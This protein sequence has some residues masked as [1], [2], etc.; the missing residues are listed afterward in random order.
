MISPPHKGFAGDTDFNP[1]TFGESKD[2]ITLDGPNKTRYT[3]INQYRCNTLVKQYR[4]ATITGEDG[5][6]GGLVT[7]LCWRGKKGG[8]EGMRKKGREGR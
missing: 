1:Q 6:K 3:L 2:A 5:R 8:R 4:C 7:H